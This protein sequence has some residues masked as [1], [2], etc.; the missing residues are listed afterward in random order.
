MGGRK[1]QLEIEN[2]FTLHN[3]K[4]DDR[5]VLFKVQFLGFE[6]MRLNLLELSLMKSFSYNWLF[7]HGK[8]V[9]HVEK[10]VN[11]ISKSYYNF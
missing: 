9:T 7:Q 3:C 2:G 4:L 11:R 10:I 8:A 6:S 1:H 5:T